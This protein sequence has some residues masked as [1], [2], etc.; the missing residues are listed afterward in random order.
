VLREHQDPGPRQ[1]GL[2]RDGGAQA[3]VGA[4]RWHADVGHDDVWSLT[5][6]RP[7]QAVGVARRPDDVEVGAFQQQHQA[8][9][10]QRPRPPR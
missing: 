6:R 7:E 3:V 4:V 1:A 9:P 5:G 10:Q 8:F 2:D